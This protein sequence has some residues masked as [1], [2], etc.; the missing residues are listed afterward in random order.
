[1]LVVM[2]GGSQSRGRWHGS[3]LSARQPTS[4]PIRF[5]RARGGSTRPERARIAADPDVPER[6]RGGVSV[7]HHLGMETE[8][9][10]RGI[11]NSPIYVVATETSA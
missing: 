1:M 3:V 6:V 5:E 9:T 10:V 11:E 2:K 8:Q 7:R 4:R